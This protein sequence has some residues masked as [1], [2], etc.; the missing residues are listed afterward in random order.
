MPGADGR[1]LDGRRVEERIRL[2]LALAEPGRPLGRNTSTHIPSWSWASVEGKIQFPHG[3][4]GLDIRNIAPE[5]DLV[6]IETGPSQK[7]VL[8]LANVIRINTHLRFMHGRV[9]SP[10]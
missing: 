9:G 4:L 3:T 10:W 1:H 7:S 2:L 8:R 5:V 6:G